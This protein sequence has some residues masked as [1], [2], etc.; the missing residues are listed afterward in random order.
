MDRTPMEELIEEYL[1]EDKWSCRRIHRYSME[2]KIGY[3]PRK[4]ES[5]DRDDDRYDY[6]RVG[7]IVSGIECYT[8]NTKSDGSH[9]RNIR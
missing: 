4:D 2:S 1:S 5:E 9:G 8:R 6:K 3:E 7:D